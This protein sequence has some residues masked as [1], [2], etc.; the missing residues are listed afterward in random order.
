MNDANLAYAL[1]EWDVVC[2]A[3]RAGRQHLL[4]R[5]GGVSEQ[6]DQFRPEH[7][8]FWFWPTRFHQSPDQLTSDG[9][10]LLA[11]RREKHAGG[12]RFAVDLLAK[13]QEVRYLTQESQLAPL[14]EMHI[15]AADTARTRFHYREPGLFVFLVRIFA[16]PHLQ[17]YIETP[18]I[19]GCKSWIELPAAPSASD[20]TP[21][22]SD[23]AFVAVQAEFSA[24]FA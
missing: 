16:V 12:N 6:D 3:L 23:E 20:L 15:L 8:Q 11:Q 14:A 18:E 22:I 1:K 21:V 7:D 2:D 9:Q 13:V 19:A 17:L 4:L 24:S 5:K 10:N